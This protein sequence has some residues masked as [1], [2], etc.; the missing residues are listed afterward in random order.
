MNNK[1]IDVTISKGQVCSSDP[2]VNGRVEIEIHDD[3]SGL[4]ICEAHMSVEQFGEMMAR[5]G[6]VHVKAE[7]PE[8]W[9][10]VGAKRETKF[11]NVPFDIFSLKKLRE[12]AP[13]IDEALKPYEVDGWIGD[14]REFL[15]GHRST[16]LQG[17]VK[18]QRVG[19]VR[20]VKDGKAVKP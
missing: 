2:E 1:L 15:N 16:I 12:D 10:R 3:V 14:R 19:F 6:P 18:A 20:W 13:E 17:D 7:I 11:E 4:L 8:N 5:N 9:D